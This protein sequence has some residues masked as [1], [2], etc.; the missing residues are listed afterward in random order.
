MNIC[1]NFNTWAFKNLY[2]EKDKRI[3]MSFTAPPAYDTV[4]WQHTKPPKQCPD[5][6]FSCWQCP[7]TFSSQD[8]LYLHQGPAWLS[9]PVTAQPV[10]TTVFRCP[11]KSSLDT[12]TATHMLIAYISLHNLYIVLTAIKSSNITIILFIPAFSHRQ[13]RPKSNGHQT[14]EE[15]ELPFP[16]IKSYL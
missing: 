14:A 2:E 1:C 8:R 11:S 3:V 9:Q 12:L 13:E 5:D 4:L 6:T 10:L 7:S 15:G 16:Q